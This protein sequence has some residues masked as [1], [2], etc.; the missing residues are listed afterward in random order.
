MALNEILYVIEK[1]QAWMKCV[2]VGYT[3]NVEI[4][5]CDVLQDRFG[6]KTACMGRN[7]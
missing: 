3:Y 5:F 1:V 2:P 4:K 7:I 6:Y